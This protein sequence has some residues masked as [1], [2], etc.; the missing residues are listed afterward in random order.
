[1][2][3]GLVVDVGELGVPVRVLAVITGTLVALVKAPDQGV[4]LYTFLFAIALAF[5]SS[6]AS[7]HGIWRPTRVAD[8]VQASTANFGIGATTGLA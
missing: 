8:K 7:Y 1:V 4:D 5:V 2:I 6:I 3:G